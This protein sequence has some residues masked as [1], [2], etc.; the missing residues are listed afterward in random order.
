M[1]FVCIVLPGLLARQTLRVCLWQ[2][3]SPV[4][5]AVSCLAAVSAR[6]SL[7]DSLVQSLNF[8]LAHLARA[9]G[10]R[11]EPSIV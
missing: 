4:F 10:Q 6:L 7:A 9:Q 2:C 3:M 11:F 1:H 5:L 8:R